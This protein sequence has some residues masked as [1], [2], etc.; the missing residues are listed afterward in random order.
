[1]RA[2]RRLASAGVPGY[3]VRMT[4]LGLERDIVD[5]DVLAR[6][7][8]HFKDA[9]LSLPTF[10]QLAEPDLVSD[11]V[12]SRLTDV[13]P[14][15]AH[16]LNLF[17]VHWFNGADRASRVT[18]PEH[19]VLPP[20]LT[21][22]EAP[23]IVMLGDAFPM[24]RAHKVL[25]AYSCLA[26]RLVTGRFDPSRHRAVWP[27]TGNYCRGGVAIS[28]ILGC[29]GVAV[30]PEGMSQERFDWLQRWVTT[31]E[32]VIRT[33]GTESNVKE[34]YDACAALSEDPGNFILNQFCEF[35][36]HLGHYLATGRALQQV[37]EH[38]RG[39]D[40]QLRLAGY[41][42]A[43][44]SAGTLA[45]GDYLKAEYGA[46]IAA[47]EAQECPTLLDNGFGEHNIQGIGDK[48]VPY[49]HNVMNTDFAVGIS[50]RHTDGLGL[51]FNTEAG[52]AFARDRKG[53]PAALVD[54]LSRFGFS[55]LAN[56]LAA[57]T[58]ARH[59][60]LGPHDA[61][62]T[63]ATDGW[64][65]Y[66]SETAKIQAQRYNG[67]FDALDAAETW[68]AALGGGD[69]RLE[70]LT[71]TARKRVFNLGYYTWVEQQGVSV[72]EFE[73]RREARFWRGLQDYLPIW[74]ELIED[75]NRRV[76]AA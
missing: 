42:S 58:M 65:L 12:R 28:R 25:A 66:E 23:I 53:L 70:E 69:H 62:L 6:T 60:D 64:E 76:R 44:G 43:T 22:V 40:Q 11:E 68:G 9:G 54:T 3:D 52:R 61:V 59:M 18:V 8:R 19:V 49:I 20:A 72:E 7:A 17:R 4:A 2:H 48:H 26:P 63:V 36:N 37:F 1:M 51:V 16:P 15:A 45:A 5:D 34:I 10:A 71:H 14:D 39:Y 75:F 46:R 24:I 27:S 31:E 73:A 35:G 32:D 57:I 74:D 56:T 13:D 33:P 50:D 55:G 30:L 29:R 47:V 21:G 38:V 67:G 41:T